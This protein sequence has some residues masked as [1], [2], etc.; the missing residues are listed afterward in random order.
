MFVRFVL[1]FLSNELIIA[2]VQFREY[3]G[4]EHHCVINVLL[5]CLHFI[6]TVLLDIYKFPIHCLYIFSSL[7]L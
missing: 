4:S 2:G 5:F 1:I 3:S 7:K 6:L